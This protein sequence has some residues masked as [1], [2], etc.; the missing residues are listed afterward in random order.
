MTLN[1]AEPAANPRHGY[2]FSDLHVFARRSI[3]GQAMPQ[4]VRTVEQAHTLVLGGDIFDFKWS[5]HASMEHSLAAAEKWL[6]DLMAPHQTCQFHFILGNHDAAPPFVERLE[7]LAANT[8]NFQW[9]RYYVRL[10]HCLF[11]HG[12]IADD[13]PCHDRLDARRKKKDRSASPSNAAHL[14]YDLAV[15]ARLHKAAISAA[16]RPQ[17][18]LQRLST[19]AEQIGHGPD[20]GVKDVY[21]GHIHQDLDGIEFGDLCFHNGGAAIKG[22]RFRIIETTL[23]DQTR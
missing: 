7:A 23:A 4:I 13:Q 21:F 19:Y 9:H 14:L 6:L 2:F 20:D 3:A 11:L 5:T 22:L 10:Q 8:P 17:A 1:P 15:H 18:I 12:D 16:V